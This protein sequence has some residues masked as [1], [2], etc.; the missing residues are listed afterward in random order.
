MFVV[1]WQMEKRITNLVNEITSERWREEKKERKTRM[2]NDKNKE[3]SYLS[4]QVHRDENFLLLSS[5]I[6]D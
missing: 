1:G 5:E 4:T 6:R 2:R 3:M